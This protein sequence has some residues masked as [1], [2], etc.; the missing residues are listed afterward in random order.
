MKII[1]ILIALVLTYA[2]LSI[3]VSIL[4]EAWNSKKSSRGRM[5]SA[6]ITKMLNDELNMNYGYLLLNHPL[7][8]CL[9][10]KN[11]SGHIQYIQPG[12][13]A[14][15]LIDIISKQ[16]METTDENLLTQPAE[17][18]KKGLLQMNES[19]LKDLLIAFYKKSN[20]DY[21]TL[22]HNIEAWYN[23]NMERLSY[24]YK[25]R[26]SNPLRILGLAVALLL[27][28]DSIHFFTI[29]SL[30]DTFRIELVKTA[31]QF[32]A[33][34]NA[35][36]TEYH[37]AVA[38]YIP[39]LKNTID[40]ME[41]KNTRKETPAISAALL[42]KIANINLL[43]TLNKAHLQQAQQIIDINSKLGIP[44][45]WSKETPPLCYFMKSEQMKFASQSPSKLEDYFQQRQTNPY[46]FLQWLIG[47]LITGLMLSFGAPFW[48]DILIQLVNIRKSAT[49]PST[50]S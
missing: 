4:L 15:A 37:K 32:E 3:L 14:D 20:H 9:R 40:S 34:S 36:N 43:D 29:L 26:Q 6:S 41:Y 46:Y 13:F 44:L 12:L 50:N 1:E 11:Q 33:K 8:E 7:L 31:E 23:S 17:S 24:Q 21:N 18:F 30:D 42:D 5:L 28:L 47:I 39:I 45:G 49:K 48:F 10:E 25:K 19:P 27:N 38:E 22:K 35:L 16:S 2:I